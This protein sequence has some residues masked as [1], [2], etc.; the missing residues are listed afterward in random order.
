MSFQIF[1][2]QLFNHLK[3]KCCKLKGSNL[4]TEIFTYNTFEG[5]LNSISAKVLL[6]EFLLYGEDLFAMQ[7]AQGSVQES[8]IASILTPTGAIAKI[9]NP[10]AHG[11]GC[12][13]KCTLHSVDISDAC[14]GFAFH[15]FI[16]VFDYSRA[17]NADAREW[18]NICRKSSSMYR[19]DFK[20][21]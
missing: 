17:A 18:T 6:N 5:I 3:S 7:N 12:M 10:W 16:S 1:L 13:E 14:Q 21:T 4:A 20:I 15:F 9:Q 2:F 11:C 19:C 8:F